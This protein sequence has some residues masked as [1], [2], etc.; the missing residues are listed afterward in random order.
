M[1]KGRRGKN[2]YRVRDKE[3]T[4]KEDPVEGELVER[5]IINQVDAPT[6]KELRFAKLINKGTDP[7][8]AVRQVSTV[9]SNKLEGTR[10]AEEK[11]SNELLKICQQKMLLDISKMAPKGLKKLEELLEAKKEVI[12]KFGDRQELN[13]PKVQL[14]AAKALVELAMPDGV[15]AHQPS[16]INTVIQI[17]SE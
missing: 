7:L 12:D 8:H 1:S 16:L 9:G 11:K 15:S 13:D 3:D 17:V 4:W 6:V 5:D 14:G 2:D 10:K